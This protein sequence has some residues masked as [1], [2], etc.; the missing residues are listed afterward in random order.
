MASTDDKTPVSEF[1]F[2]KLRAQILEGEFAPG[3]ALPGER[4]LSRRFGVNRGAVRESLKRLEQLRLVEIQHGEH[5]RVTDFRR[6]GTIEL[7][8]DLIVSSDGRLDLDTARSMFEVG[9]ILRIGIVRA[10]AV[11]SGAALAPA[12]EAALGRVRKAG[13][14]PGEVTQERLA[15]WDVLIEGTD[16]VG[17]RLLSNSLRG[18]NAHWTRL[19]RLAG[20]TEKTDLRNLTRIADAVIA[21]DADAAERAVREKHGKQVERT[22]GR[23]E[24][25]LS[26]KGGRM[27]SEDAAG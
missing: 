10:A 25:M 13:R 19:L 23:I 6:T 8:A 18:I 14:D 12:L 2:R 21:G 20:T 7:L 1:V 11:R 24:Q 27:L 16:S 17:L 5:T 4:E 26:R 15:F 22:L 3:A 9:V